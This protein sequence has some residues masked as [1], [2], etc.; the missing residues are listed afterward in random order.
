MLR[1]QQLYEGMHDSAV[2]C[3]TLHGGRLLSSGYD[4]RLRVW[5]VERSRD[6]SHPVGEGNEADEPRES[7]LVRRLC[8]VQLELADV[9][10][11]DCEEGGW[12][13]ACGQGLSVLRLS[14]EC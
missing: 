6:G 11:L 5:G 4:Q 7:W 10:G 13:V 9:S 14:A 2:K 3:L 8:G 12:V 1:C